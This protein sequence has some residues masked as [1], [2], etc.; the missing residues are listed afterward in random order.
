[1]WTS[2]EVPFIFAN[3]DHAHARAGEAVQ[4]SGLNGSHVFDQRVTPHAVNGLHAAVVRRTHRPRPRQV[5][6]FVSIQTRPSTKIEQGRTL[7]MHALP[8][9]QLAAEAAPPSR[10]ARLR[11]PQYFRSPFNACEIVAQACLLLFFSFELFSLF[12]FRISLLV[13]P[14]G[15]RGELE[16]RSESLP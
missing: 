2:F 3:C 7:V 8:L 12:F 4:T 11:L 16:Q 9:Q 15:N 10:G 1:M 5:L 14:R 6:Y 13:G